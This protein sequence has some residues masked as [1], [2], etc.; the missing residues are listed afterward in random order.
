MDESNRPDQR[1]LL[2]ELSSPRF[3]L[4]ERQGH[5]RLISQKWPHVVV[6]IQARDGHWFDFNCECM[7]Y[8]KARPSIGIWD[9][10]A[11]TSLA[12]DA[13]PTMG[14]CYQLVFR[15][16]WENGHHLYH[17]MERT[18]F[19]GHDNWS[20]ELR[21]NLWVPERGLTQLCQEIHGILNSSLY[22]PKQSDAT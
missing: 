9:S 21:F 14:G 8:P 16:D 12:D 7:G 3:E 13:R 4:G 10:E 2:T 6:G 11:Q 5:W 1:A 17:P 15:T 19:A 20:G 22:Q 18:A